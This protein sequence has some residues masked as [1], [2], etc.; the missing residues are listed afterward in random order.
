MMTQRTTLPNFCGKLK[1]EI[2]KRKHEV[3]DEI[4]RCLP[5]LIAKIEKEI[6]ANCL[7][8]RLEK[9][10]NINTS[11][12]HCVEGLVLHFQANGLA[13]GYNYNDTGV[14]IVVTWSVAQC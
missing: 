4:K 8:G 3:A 2:S 6:L 10:F 14:T 12:Y 1:A 13:I 11:E 5:G 9:T 7:T